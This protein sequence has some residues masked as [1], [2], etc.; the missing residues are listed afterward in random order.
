M[1]AAAQDGGALR[2]IAHRLV[3]L[4]E[5]RQRIFLEQIRGHGIDLQQLPIVAGPR[6]VRVPL[7]HAQHQQWLLWKMRPASAA[8]HLA[9]PMRLRGDVDTV[10]LQKAFDAIVARH[11]SLRTSF[12]MQENNLAQVIALTANVPVRLLEAGSVGTDERTIRSL[13]A[14]ELR[15]PFDLEA[16]LP[17]RVTLIRLAPRE[18]V[19]LVVLH[20]IVADAWS[21]DLMLEELGALYSAQCRGHEAALADLPIQYADLAIWQQHWMK[22]KLDEQL[23][24]WREQLGEAGQSQALLPPDRPRVAT[25]SYR[26]ETFRFD[27]DAELSASLMG[28]A[29]ARGVT[30]FTVLVASLKA[31]LFRYSGHRDIRVGTPV[32]NRHRIETER[33]IGFLVNTV[34][35][36][37]DLGGEP[38][39]DE[40]VS[41][42]NR[43]I[44]SALMHQDLPFA[45]L[46]EA[47]NPQ[48]SFADNP[49]FQVLYTHEIGRRTKPI[50]LPGL[51]VEPLVQEH[52]TAQ[53]DLS[54]STTEREGGVTGSV[55]YA[56]ELYDSATIA[57]FVDHWRNLL[58]R[59]I[60]NPRT[61]IARV[62]L[63]CAMER[64]RVLAEWNRTSISHG[65]PE[66]LHELIEA[67]VA[68]TPNA[69]CVA[70]DGATLDFSCLD[71]CANAVA[72]RLQ[73]CA[74]G[75][76]D[77]VAVCMSRSLEL[78]VSLFG[79]L[80]AGAAYVPLDPDYPTSRLAFM[81]SDAKP[82]VVL[83]QHTLAPLV[84]S[85][86]ADVP[87][88]NMDGCASVP[89]N[90]APLSGVATAVSPENLAYC[91]YTSGSTGLPKGVAISHRG[92][93]NF[94]QSFR[95]KPGLQQGDRWLAL[96]SL[97][98]DMA[99]L[100]TFLPLMAGARL[101]LVDRAVAV[102]PT[103]ILE[104]I[105]R[106]GITVVQATPTMWSM[107]VARDAAGVLSEC[108]ALSGG[109]SL[110]SDLAD[111]L[112]D[113]AQAVWN[114][115]GPTETTV[116]SAVHEL[117]GAQREPLVGTPIDNTVV[118][119]LNECL[120]PVP[121]GVTGDLYIG[122]VGVARGYFGR[123]ALTAERFTPNP[124]GKRPG[125]RLYRTG[126][127]G[128]YRHDGVIEC[129]GRSDHQV[130]IRGFRIE[131][132]E[133]EAQLR[134][135]PAVREAAVAAHVGSDGTKFL[136]AY[137]VPASRQVLATEAPGDSANG[138]FRQL[139]EHVKARLP[140]YMVPAHFVCL[141]GLPKTPNG[142]LDRKALAAPVHTGHA[143]R[144]FATPRSSLEGELVALW[145][146]ALGVSPIGIHDNFFELG[147][148]S[149]L[150]VQLAETLSR[151]IGREVPLSQLFQSQ[152]VAELAEA[153][154]IVHKRNDASSLVILET[155]GSRPALCCIHPG[156]GQL[157]GYRSLARCFRDHRPVYGLQSRLFYRDDWVDDSIESMA[158]H[159]A[160]QIVHRTQ[161]RPVHLLGWSAGC[162]IAAETVRCLKERGQPVLSLAMIDPVAFL[163]AAV[164]RTGVQSAELPADAEGRVATWI[165]QARHRVQWQKLLDLCD[166]TTWMELVRRLFDRHLET[167]S[168]S[169]AEEYVLLTEAQFFLLMRKYTFR[170]APVVTN[171]WWASDTLRAH[172]ISDSRLPREMAHEAAT[173]EADHLN[174]VNSP[175]LH[176]QLQA[177]LDDRD[178]LVSPPSKKE[179]TSD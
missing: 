163:D 118:H 45:Q 140:Q 96:A 146:D 76:D 55:L 111:R 40:V 94:L 8:Y 128:R 165:G 116:Y 2:E 154:S 127:L 73:A 110:P 33:L 129:L 85:L 81:L 134:T 164:A 172:S 114:V 171:I 178:T 57:R 43:V 64:T 157:L 68:K 1:N 77:R 109:E 89:E 53:V 21:L 37:T 117:T 173:I 143:R 158:A 87:A 121:V 91:I 44:R 124:F 155:G 25:L 67:Q 59:M 148:H 58:R 141:E 51:E 177:L 147:G 153:L 15:R 131:L 79:I 62:D 74:V 130:K 122:G 99:C 12:R 31:L 162:F 54:V 13:M 69:I 14:D 65:A 20:H 86:G 108:R 144:E 18:H 7:S 46:V 102:D 78:V 132:G 93:V 48:R 56:T 5:D 92:I 88:W 70:R 72:T 82:R 61:S 119:V 150:A 38:S 11:E 98:F 97:S 41:R 34:V 175:E 66:S 100:D 167:R 27:F 169:V 71:K 159:Y 176:R 104:C 138:L 4:P 145:Q 63:L 103:A 106:E 83:T 26:A 84:K 156:G 50:H 19:L 115:Y 39:F 95:R 120:Q 166:G 42:V 160:Q 137:I 152:T 28:F 6:P 113:R 174:I 3:R 32:A 80:K 168:L 9:L 24:Y 107:L 52:Q 22:E 47:L 30:V 17:I 60:D 75:P 133:I 90:A 136:V 149:L 112:I 105:R 126:D 16:G 179:V 123:P 35:L 135:H 29:G 151:S 49:L 23:A 170:A 142:K 101:V 139:S 10:A 161:G 125:E 36:R